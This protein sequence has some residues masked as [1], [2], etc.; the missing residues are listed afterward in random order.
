[1]T[2]LKASSLV[3]RFAGLKDPRI[4]RTKLHQL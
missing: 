1:M 4:E 2:K 3:E